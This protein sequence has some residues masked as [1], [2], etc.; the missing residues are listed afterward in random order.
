[1]AAKYNTV[2]P[3]LAALAL[4]AAVPSAHRRKQNAAST[5]SPETQQS[6]PAAQQPASPSNQ[7]T[8]PPSAPVAGGGMLTELTASGSAKFSSAQIVAACG[9]KTGQEITREDLQ[10]A[11]NRLAATGLFSSVKYRF[12]SKGSNVSLEFQVADGPTLPV[13]FDNFPWFTDEELSNDIRQAVGIFDGTSPESGSYVDAIGLAIEK[14][15]Q[16]LGVQGRVEHRLIQRPVGSGME[17]QFRLVGVTLNVGE[18]DF[19]DPVAQHDERVKERLQ[20]LIGKPFSRYYT[21]V[22]VSEQVRPIYLSQGYLQVQFGPP[23][24]RFSGNPN[25]PEL[26]PVLVV[27]PVQPGKQYTWNGV[28][29][30]GNTV[31]TASALD[32]M[33]GLQPGQVADGLALEAGWQQVR[34]QYGA[35]GY[36]D[37][38]LDTQPSFDDAKGTVSYSVTITEGPPYSMGKL[39]I[40]GLSVE[41]E[42]RVRDAW[43]IRPGQ[44]FD[45]NY[46]QAFLGDIV[47]K[48]LA[49]LPVHYRYIG[50][51]LQRHPQNHTVDVMLDFE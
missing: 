51:Y 46:Y 47:K 32:R 26:S 12:A 43:L 15:L 36:L 14:Q 41:A 35:K 33:I 13:A 39:V 49:D 42:E 24:A 50:R 3:L 27:V 5:P 29:W 28:N 6:A 22:F 23:E 18:V 11:A 37:A 44:P 25:R 34:Q 16:S 7:Q 30:N 9:L 21:N 1:V 4:P 19:T 17:V 20:D 31:Y 38:S 40:S 45:L 10:L 48:A 8:A 2:L